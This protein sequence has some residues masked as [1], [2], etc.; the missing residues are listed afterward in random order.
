M[1]P[2]EF[3]YMDEWTSEQIANFKDDSKFYRGNMIIEAAPAPRATIIA[4][5][6]SWFNY[7]LAGVD[8]IDCLKGHYGYDIENNAKPG[9]TLENMI[10]GTQIDNDF[11]Q[12]SPSIDKIIQRINELKPKVFLFSGGGNDIAGDEFDSYLNHEKSGLPAYREEFAKEIIDGVFRKY[13]EDLISLVA[14]VSPGTY[15]VT[16]GYAHTAPTGKAVKLLG[17]SFS[18]PWLLPSLTKKRIF[19]KSEQRRIVFDLI[20]KFNTML[21]SLAE[22]FKPHFRHIDLRTIIN[23]D[24]DWANE[25]HLKNSGFALVAQQFHN[26]IQEL[27]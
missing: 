20:D 2:N 21:A 11:N 3:S 4:E 23:P 10:Y 6:D 1:Q 22:E 19:D 16:H 25:L 12:V 9:D 15:I 24:N 7:S 26:E 8:I 17:F 5:G 13:Y 18:G 14:G 27:S